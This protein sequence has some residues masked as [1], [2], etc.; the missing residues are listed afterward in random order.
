M[1]VQ[2]VSERLQ[3]HSAELEQMDVESLAIFGSAARGDAGPDS[4]IDVLIEF[5]QPVGL[6]HFLDVKEF[7]EEILGCRVDLVTR[8]ALKHQLRERILEEAVD[9][10]WR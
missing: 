2:A 9:A 7:L 8:A 3:A 1:N 6:F 4:D 10:R 5:S